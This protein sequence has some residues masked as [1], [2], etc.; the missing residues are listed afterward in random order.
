MYPINLAASRGNL[1]LVRLLLA[2]GAN[3]NLHK[4]DGFCAI[5]MACGEGHLAI[6]KEL[7]KA[8]ASPNQTDDFN[9]YPLHFTAR[10]GRVGVSKQSVL[11]ADSYMGGERR[12]GGTDRESC[13]R[14]TGNHLNVPRPIFT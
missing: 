6:V 3:V 14:F 5:H 1:E 8:G 11:R 7:I 9:P 2:H 10:R 13:S 12:G 4:P